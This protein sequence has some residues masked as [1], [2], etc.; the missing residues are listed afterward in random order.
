MWAKEHG[1]SDGLSARD[2]SRSV[3]GS[4]STV[5]EEGGCAC[6]G[7]RSILSLNFSSICARTGI[8]FSLVLV[9]RHRCASAWEAVIYDT[10]G[11]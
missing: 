2:K 6:V 11:L 5:D 1:T 8:W 7:G 9:T 10:L 3:E 4:A